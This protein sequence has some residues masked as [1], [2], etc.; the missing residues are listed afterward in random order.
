MRDRLIL[1]LDVPTVAEA[2]A[3]VAGLDGVVTFYKIGMWLLFQPGTDKLIDD[4][5]AA[6]K[7]VF[8]DYK[9]YDIGETVKRGIQS[10]ANRGI[11]FATVHGDAAIIRAAV[12]G[13]GNGTLKL[14][15]I[16]VL[17]SLDDQ[18]L[19][20]M[21]YR[22]GVDALI[23]Q[24]V[25]TAMECGC[26]GIVASAHDNPD[27]LRAD[28]GAGELLV[29]TPGGAHGGRALGR[30]SPQCGSGDGD[31]ERGG[32]FGGGSAYPAGGGSGGRWLRRYWR[33][34]RKASSSFLKRRTRK[35]FSLEWTLPESMRPPTQNLFASFS[36]KK[37]L[38]TGQPTTKRNAA[39]SD[40]PGGS[41]TMPLSDTSSIRFT[42]S[43]ML[44]T[45]SS[46]I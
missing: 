26:D 38:L 1:A 30:P 6:G 35:L 23:A 15:A 36:K 29:V 16:T 24:R 32:L 5:V 8:L 12:Q 7:Q 2:R 37:A 42:A 41:T 28:A 11:A 40:P 43:G 22:L 10:A 39:T 25:R 19:A 45:G 20:E 33:R 14:L 4:L 27:K 44:L 17:T 31:R 3:L 46:P 34:W 9:M 18:A 13:R 21:G